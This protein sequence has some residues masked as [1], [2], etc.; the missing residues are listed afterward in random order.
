MQQEQNSCPPF[1][2]QGFDINGGYRSSGHHEREHGI[3]G[4]GGIRILDVLWRYQVRHGLAP[5]GD[6]VMVTSLVYAKHL[7][8]AV[9]AI[10]QEPGRHSV[11]RRSRR[12]PQSGRGTRS[13][14][15]CRPSSEH[16]KVQLKANAAQPS[17][18]ANAHAG[19]AHIADRQS[20]LRRW[21][22]GRPRSGLANPTR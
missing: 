22:R 16:Q 14:A 12:S 6:G 17:T 18:P 8:T 4:C 10:G 3:G 7:H 21:F 20:L 5:Q 19:F 15:L 2:D 9:L 13:K 1:I 11:L